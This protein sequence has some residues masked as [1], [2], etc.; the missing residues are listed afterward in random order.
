MTVITF[1]KLAYLEKLKSSGIPESHAKAHTL[2][3]EEALGEAVATKSD[4]QELRH[5]LQLVR[6]EIDLS[7]RDLTIR[8]GSMILAMGSLLIAIKYFG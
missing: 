7:K 4:I 2:A 8:L 5:E 6:T 1:D 3:L